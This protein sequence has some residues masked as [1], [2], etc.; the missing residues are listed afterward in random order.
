MNNLGIIFST[1]CNSVYVFFCLCPLLPL[2]SSASFHIM[3]HY[4]SFFFFYVFL[5]FIISLRDIFT[6]RILDYIKFII[7]WV[8]HPPMLFFFLY[9][10]FFTLI[11]M[12]L[13]LF[14]L[15]LSLFFSF[16]LSQF[17]F[18][19]GI[20]FQKYDTIFFLKV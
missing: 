16:K 5:Y 15:P 19:R 20:H 18:N 6:L 11:M 14:P 4:M 13:V 10:I 8:F 1:S 12:L 7:K 9:I 17:Q 3:R 2:V